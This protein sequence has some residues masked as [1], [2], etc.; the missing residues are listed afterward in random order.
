MHV[1]VT[2]QSKC[3][4]FSSFEQ[5]FERYSPKAILYYVELVMGNE[6][7]I[8]VINEYYV[9]GLQATACYKV[10]DHCTAAVLKKRFP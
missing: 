4:G 6:W 1:R 10:E 9:V 7:H 8:T 5:N 3:L 2:P